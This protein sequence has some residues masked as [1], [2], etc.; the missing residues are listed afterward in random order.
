M[1]WTLAII[2]IALVTWNAYQDAR[3]ALFDGLDAELDAFLE[4]LI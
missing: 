1:L 3:R 4:A 2:V